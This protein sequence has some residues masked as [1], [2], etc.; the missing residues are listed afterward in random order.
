MMGQAKQGVP[1][2]GYLKSQRRPEAWV[3]I[4]SGNSNRKSFK[5]RTQALNAF[6]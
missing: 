1:I 4:K 3:L 5:N 6:F 2:L